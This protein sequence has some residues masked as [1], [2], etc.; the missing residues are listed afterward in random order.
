MELID[1]YK[2]KDKLYDKRNGKLSD[3]DME[4]WHMINEISITYD[5]DKVVKELEHI[6][7][8]CLERGDIIGCSDFKKAIEIVKQGII[9][10][11]DS[12]NE[13]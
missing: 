12:L 2:L 11:D 8:K 1:K 13:V 5:I 9:G 7:E 3:T 6:K 4:I 10:M